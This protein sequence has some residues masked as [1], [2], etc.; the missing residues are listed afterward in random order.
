VLPDARGATHAGR[1]EIGVRYDWYSDLIGLRASNHVNLAALYLDER[2]RI[3]EEEEQKRVFYVAMTRAREHLM[4]SVPPLKVDQ[5]SFVA[6]LERSA[7][8]SSAAT[9][10]GSIAV[11]KGKIDLRILAG[12][13]ERLSPPVERGWRLSAQGDWSGFVHRWDERGRRYE[14]ALKEPLF[15]SPTALKKRE[16]ETA[17]RFELESDPRGET[18]ALLLG[19]LAHGFLQQL[20]FS[21]P[22]ERI[23]KNLADYME[24]QPDSSDLLRRAALLQELSDIFTIFLRSRVFAELCSAKIIGREVPLLMPWDG[25]VMEGVIDLIYEKHGRLYLAD[26]KT[27]RVKKPELQRAAEPHRRQAAIYA[28]A[29]WRSLQRHVD[30]FELIFLRLGESVLVNPSTVR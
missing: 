13:R 22:P 6:M 3:R 29:A 15:V 16:L 27:D 1:V 18:D 24:R 20:D 26:Y 19:S 30:G 21:A 25:Q 14:A 4:I 17:E 8:L 9:D 11:G 5:G 2:K 23:K 28:E 10:Q 7:D 12:C